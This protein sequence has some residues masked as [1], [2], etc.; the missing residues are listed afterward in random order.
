MVY[1]YSDTDAVKHCYDVYVRVAAGEGAVGSGYFSS[2]DTAWALDG[3]IAGAGAD[4]QEYML[5]AYNPAS[6]VSWCKI[7][8]LEGEPSLITSEGEKIKLATCNDKVISK[9]IEIDFTSLS[10]NKANWD[11]MVVLMDSN[12]DVL[13]VETG[14]VTA[15][16]TGN[17]IGAANLQFDVNLEIKGNAMNRMPFKITKEIGTITTWVNF[18]TV[19]L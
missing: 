5:A 16:T 15:V 1:G 9:N 7:G 10:V 11:S 8:V 17:G 19:Q 14:S 13:F 12:I 18:V 4:I 3:F 6:H 2:T